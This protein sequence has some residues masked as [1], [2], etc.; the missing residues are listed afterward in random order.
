VGNFI[1]RL[2]ENLQ[3]SKFTAIELDDISGRILKQL[4]QKERIYNKGYEETEL[5]NNFYDVAISNIPFGNYEVYDKDYNKL[6]FKVHD[7]FIAKTLDKVRTGGIIAFIT[8]RRTLDKKSSDVREYIAKRADLLGAI[9]LPTNAFKKIG[10]TEVTTDIIFLQKRE[11]IRQ[12]L[13]EWV[14]ANKYIENVYLNEYF[15]NNSHLV[16]GEIVETT[17][18]FGND[19]D[20]KLDLDK[21]EDSLEDA[22]SYLP[23]NVMK[24]V[25]LKSSKEQNVIPAIEGVKDYSYTIYED[26]I[27]YRIGSTMTEFE[28][29]GI[30][31][32]RIRGLIQVRDVLDD[33]INMECQNISDEELQTQRTKLNYEYDKFVKKYGNIN[34]AINKKAF[35]DDA[36]YTLLCA[37]E[38][39][40]D[41]TKKYT[42][43]DIF[44]KR[45]IQPH[46][47]ID[48]AETAEEG[49]ILSLN[50]KGRVDLEYISQITDK[51]IMEVIKELKG[52]IF[53]NPLTAKEFPKEDI[54][55]GWET[56]EEYL[57]GYVVDKLS[58]AEAFAEE[59]EMYLSNVKA[60]K[61]VQPVKLGA[62]DI[63]V[64][65]GSTWIPEEYI[66]QFAKELLKI[67]SYYDTR[68]IYNQFLG[69]WL[70]EFKTWNSSIENHQIYGTSRIQGIDILEDT[71]NLKN[72]NVYDKDE[73]DRRV[74]N[75]A[76]TLLAREKQELIKEKFKEWIF[77][78]ADRRDNVVDI[79]NRKFNRI[80][81]RTY[82]GSNLILPNI[83][84]NIDLMEHQKNAV[85]RIIYSK[86]NTLLAHCV[87]A[88]KTYSMIASCME[89]RRLGI[90]KKPLIVVPNHMLEEWGNAFYKLY[91]SA[92]ILLATKKDFEKS[93]R[94]KLISR[95]ATGDYDAIIMAHSTFGKIPVS[96]ETQTKFVKEELA[97]IEM[98]LQECDDR[99]SRT[100][101]QIETA[102]KNAEKRLKELMETKKKDNVINFEQL[103]VDF[104]F[105]DEAHI[106]KNLY[107]YT[108]MGN[109]A[110][111]QKTRSQRAFDMYIKTQ[112]LLNQNNDK[113]VCFATGTPISNSMAEL[114]TM[115][116]YLQP[117][118][119]KSLGLS[120]FDEWASTFGEVVSSFEIAPEG[121]GYRVRERFSKFHNIPE[122]MNIFKEVADIKTAKMLNLPAP[123]LRDDKCTIISVE[124]SQNLKEYIDSLVDRA[125]ILRRTRVDPK[126]DN[127]LKVTT[128]GKKAALDIRLINSLYEDDKNSKINLA[129]EEIYKVYAEG[130]DIKATQLVFCDMSTP[131]GTMESPLKMEQKDGVW[132]LEESQFEN[133]YFDL[134]RKLM[135]KGIP[136]NEI[137]FIHSAKNEVEKEEI[138]RKTRAGEI[139][140][141]LGSTDKM[142]AGTNVQ[143]RLKAIHDLDVPWRP[144]QLEQR[145][146]RILRPGNMNDEVQIFRY[147]VRNSLDAYLWQSLEIKQTYIGQVYIGDTSIRV[148]E[149]LDNTALTYSELKS[150][151]S[152]DPLVLEKFKVDTELQKLKDKLRV[153]NASKYRL[154][155]SIRKTIPNEIESNKNKIL[156]IKSDILTRQPKQNEDNC[157]IEVNDKIF[158]NYKDAGNEIIEFS[159]KYLEPNR[160]YKLGKYRGFELAIMKIGMEDLIADNGEYR[161]LIKVKSDSNI[162]FDLLKIPSLNIKKLDEKLDSLETQLKN[163]ENENIE[164]GRQIE[165]CKEELTKP[166][167]ELERYESLVKR[168]TE[169]DNQLN[170]DKESK[171]ILID[172]SEEDEEDNEELYEEE[173]EE[174]EVY[175]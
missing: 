18:Q 81:L 84:T 37:L 48:K 41:K 5:Q 118:T 127:M 169:I 123:K 172:E 91:P 77:Q 99:N 52:K 104:L 87:G 139:R 122:L 26:K 71:L 89:L 96:I 63:E 32:E 62:E 111:V 19:I 136:E 175:V 27:Y 137:E 92:K 60:L 25:D 171:Q 74:L 164:L 8:S 7:Y 141:L 131:K 40:D 151:A 93:R 11:Q 72:V 4:Y 64:R 160:E 23:E 97:D 12:D 13:P 94:Q 46:K 20:V 140:I 166:F 147:V 38:I 2:P 55:S 82:D 124:P 79:Y 119:L 103:G 1:G 69:K 78:D 3:N 126:I 34:L 54:L 56:A 110:G 150:I 154:E 130:N 15:K 16:L 86:G 36:E 44:T 33:L 162:Q 173:Q 101:K 116:R 143:T 109:I 88:G 145:S 168:K 102:K 57:S 128:D 35:Y 83:S 30:V 66:T 10:N 158:N 157:H 138:F 50:Q 59:D 108:K 133:I 167:A 106:F 53:R 129:V 115:Q 68:I 170:L 49:L 43:S 28:N 165:R 39:Y 155:D 112:Y 95:I 146:G 6:K 65:L 47:E 153:Y 174:E 98:A 117:K 31:A 21:L 132:E 61:E 70:V 148:M 85:A 134:K 90:A 17:N 73:N 125:D 22:I 149:D 42:K 120:N 29:K 163:I 121:T 152:G 135:Q 76:E 45:T 113:A 100:V 14:N 67:K 80:R 24:E 142:G 161:C 9:R 75:K 156:Y 114:Y 58:V 51:D 107:L 105:V 144:D 159:N